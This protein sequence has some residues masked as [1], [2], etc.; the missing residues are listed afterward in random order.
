MHLLYHHLQV[1]VIVNGIPST[2]ASKNCS[3]TFEDSL[4]P[5]VI[6][7]S[8]AMGQSGTNVTI[9]GTGFS[10]KLEDLSVTIGGVACE[11]T[12]ASTEALQCTAGLQSAGCYAV[13]LAIDGVGMAYSDDSICFQY[14]VT[15]DSFSPMMGGVTGGQVITFSGEGFPE[16]TPE[17]KDTTIIMIIITELAKRH[18]ELPWLRY[19]RDTDEFPDE[20]IMNDI[21]LETLRTRMEDINSRSPFSV[22]IG[23]TPC[24]ITE[25]SITEL[26]CIPLP[27]VEGTVAITITVRDQNITLDQE[28]TI[29]TQATPAIA[30]VTPSTGPVTGGTGV[31]ITGRLLSGLAEVFVGKS[32]CV[33]Q[34]SND[35][36]I[37]CTTAQQKPGS[38]PV[39]V[40]ASAGIAVLESEL[41]DWNED[42]NLTDL[43]PVF[44][45]ELR[46][47]EVSSSGGSVF[48]GTELSISGAGFDEDNTQV[49]IGG[50]PAEI[51]S[52][53]SSEIVCFTP[54]SAREHLIDLS[55]RPVV[56]TSSISSLVT[57]RLTWSAD[58]IEV[59]VGDS[60]TWNWYLDLPTTQAL[61]LS[62]YEVEQPNPDDPDTFV[63]RAEGFS[64]VGET[65]QFTVTFTQSGTRYFVTE[66]NFNGE[67]ILGVVH[68]QELQAVRR[69]LEVYVGNYLAEY[70][71]SGSGSP[72]PSGDDA[73]RNRRNVFL[74][75]EEEC[76]DDAIVDASIEG[77]TFDYSP[78]L[79][80]LVYCVQPQTG[81]RLTTYTIT[82]ERFSTNADGNIVTFGDVPCEIATQNDTTITCRM[83]DGADFTPPAFFPLPLSLRNTDQGFGNGYILTPSTA[84]VTLYPLIDEITPREGSVAGGTD[85]IIYGDTF[86]FSMSSLMVS[87][88]GYQCAVTSVLYSEIW[89]RTAASSGEV[90]I[91]DV[92]FHNVGTGNIIPT[93]CDEDFDECTFEYSLSHTPYVQDVSP[94]TISMAGSTTIEITGF[95]FSD[96][97]EENIV[98]LGNSPCIIIT[99]NE[100]EIS[101]EVEALAAAQ[102][103]FS[104]R[105]CNLTEGRCFGN[106]LVEEG[107]QVVSVEAASVSLVPDTGSILGGTLVTISGYGYNTSSSISVIIGSSSCQVTMVTLDTIQC[108]TSASNP[109]SAIVTVLDGRSEIPSQGDPLSFS[110]MTDATPLVS[111]ISPENGQMGDVATLFGAGFGSSPDVIEIFI[112]DEPCEVKE[113]VNTTVVTCELGVNFAGIHEI[114]LAVGG[115][116]IAQIDEGVTFTYNLVLTSFS[117]TT[118]SLAGMNTLLV[119]GLGFD[120][121][122]T[123]ITICDRVCL[124]T[125]DVPSVT[126]IECFVPPASDDLSQV[127]EMLSC[128][129][130]VNSVGMSVT[131][132]EQYVYL[133]D[134]T[135]LVTSVNVTRG[136]TEGGTRLMISGNGFTAEVTV[137]IAGS[138]CTVGTVTES[139]IECTTER[140]GRTVRAKVMVLV[141]GKG[142]A[143]S[144]VYFWYVDVWSS[145][146]TWGGGPLPQEGDFVVVP[147][148]QTL[149]L[150]TK[151]PILG[152]LLVQGGEL[153]F[154]QEKGDNEV[155]LH[156]QGGLITSGGRVEVGTEANPFMSKTQIVLYGHVLSTEIPLYGAK[157]LGLRR[158]ELDLHGRPINVT[159]TRLASTAESGEV[160]IAL[161]DYVDWEIGGRIVLSSTS[162][163]QRENEEMEIES[164]R[165]GD[166]GSILHLTQPLQYQ[167]ISVSQEVA[168]RTLETRG[169]VG[170]LTRNV[171]VRGNVN[172]EW[173]EL[174]PDCPEEF[175]PGQFEVQSCFQGRFG[176]EVVGDQFG[177]QIMIHAAVPNQGHVTARIEHIEVRHAGQ[178]FRLG[179]YPI[180][181]HLNG[182][183]TGSYVR[184]CGV[185]NTFNRAVTIHGVDHLLVEKNVAFN[186]LG[187]AYF[188]EDGI[189][190]YNIIQDNLGVFVRAS[191]SLL[192]VDITPATFW[193]VNANNI[194]RRNA[195]AGGTH[196]G[197]WYRL[198]EHPV[199]PS[200]TTSFCPR[201]QR[202][203]EFSGNTA[204]S[205]GWYGLWV[206]RQYFPSLEGRCGDSDHAP[207][208][209]DNFFSWRNDRGVEFAEVGALQLRNSV[210]L[211]NRLAGVEVTEIESIWSEEMGPLI[212]DTLIVGH[213]AISFEDFC[214]ESGIKTP[215]SYYLTVSGVTFANF[216]RPNCYPIQA[217][218]HCKVRQGGFETRYREISFVNAGDK[219]TKWQWE[220]EHIHRDL[221]GSLTQSEGPR[222]LIPFSKLLNPALCSNHP[223][224]SGGGAGNGTKGSICDGTVQFGRLAVFDPSPS[225]LRFADINITN[226]HGITHLP[227]VFKRLRGTGPGYM[228][229]V[230]LNQTFDITWLEGQALTNISYNSKISGFGVDDYIIMRQ[231]YV[232]SLDETRVAGTRDAVNASV[233][234]DPALADHGDFFVTEQNQTGYIIKGGRDFPLN[235]R[236]T[237]Y[238]T[239]RCFYLDCIP[240]PPPTLPPP[241]PPGRPENVMMWSNVSIW[242]NGE[243]PGEG[244][245]VT[246]ARDMYV[247]VD[248]DTL[249]RLDILMIEGGLEIFDDRNR[250]LVAS[251][252]IINGGR[253]V[254]GYPET[255]FQHYFTIILHGN[256]RTP[257]LLGFEFGSP[258]IGAKA[259]AV[260]GELIL[261]AEPQT[262]PTWSLLSETV[263]PGDSQLTVTEAVDWRP[264]DFV[265]VTSTS[266]DAFETEVFQVVTA[267]QN[268]VN[269]NDSFRYSH[270]GEEATIGSVRYGIRA[271]V[272]H[273]S[274]KIVI[275][276]GGPELAYEQSFGCRVLVSSNTMSDYRG[277]VQLQGVEFRGCGQLGHTESFDPRFALAMVNAGDQSTSYVRECSFHDGFS[278]AVGVFGTDG[279][280]VT[281]TV[282]HSTVGPSII[283]EGTGHVVQRNLASLSQFIGTYRER[284]EPFN[285]LWTANYEIAESTGILFTDNH[286]AGGGKAGIHTDGEECSASSP[287]T[288]QR[289]VAHS[290]L[291]CFHVGYRDGTG[292]GCSRFANMTAYGC[293]H[294]GFF[295]FSRDGVEVL[296][297]LFVNNKAAVYV[298]VIGPASLS[299]VV[300]DK[301]VSIQ[302]TNII[303]ASLNFECPDDD[304]RPAIADHKT[305]HSGIQT[306]SKGH[307]GVVIPTFFSSKGGFPKFPW[308]SAHSY[309]AIGGMSTLSSVSFV[310]F[311]KRCAERKD[312]VLATSFH[313]EDANHPIHVDRIAFASDDRYTVNGLAIQPQFK[314]FVH[315]PD[316]SSINPSDCVDMDCDGLK[317]ILI[318]D[319]DG[320]FCE[321]ESPRSLVSLAELEWDGDRR[322]GIGDFRIPKTMLT[323]SDG[324]RIPVE[325]V[326]PLKGIVRGTSF[327]NESQC[328]YNS[329]W[330]L[331]VCPN[332]DH[333][334]LVMESLDEDT[335]VRR[336]SPIGIGANGFI[337]LLNGPMDNGWCG[338]YTCQERISTF[339]GIV[340]A[341]ANYVVGL[342][343]TNPQ[344]F[345][346][347]LLNS[348][349]QEAV[350][351]RIIYTNPQRLDVYRTRSGQDVYVPPTN[352][353]LLDD[354]NLEYKDFD[355]DL[356]DAQFNPLVSDPHGANYYDRSLKQLHVNIRGSET[357][358]IITTPVIMLSL[359]I[360]T[361]VE[362][363]F[364]EQFL[365]RNLALLLEIP[366]NRIR[367]V[368][369]VM[370]TRRK[371]QA[372]GGGAGMETIELEIGDPPTQVIDVVSMNDTQTNTSDTAD[373]TN[374]TET[375]S[376]SR[377][378]ELTEMVAAAVQTGQIL[379]GSNGTLVAAEIEE[380]VPPPVDP[381][382]GVRATPSTGGPQPEDVGENSTVL[383]FFEQQQLEE[384]VAANDSSPVIRLS[385]PSRLRFTRLLGATGIMEGVALGNQLAPVVT[386][387]DNNGEIAVALGV[388]MSWRLTATLVS[389]P[390]RGFLTNSTVEFVNGHAVFEGLVFSHPGTYV[391]HFIVTIPTSADFSIR[392][393][394]VI[395]APRSL[396]LYITQQPQDGNTTFNLY[397]YPAIRVV[398]RG[399]LLR[400]H[401]WRNSSWF[402]TALVEDVGRRAVL[403]WTREV[404]RGEAYFPKIKLPANGRYRIH[405][406]A[407]TIPTELED[408]LPERITSGS[409]RINTPQFTRFIVNYEVDFDLVLNKEAEFIQVF[410]ERFVSSYPRAE[411]YNTTIRNGSIIVSTFVTARTA[412][413]L[414]DIINQATS[415][416]N[417]TLTLVFNGMT[418]VPS[419][420]VQDPAY[421]VYLEEDRLLLILATT[422]PA[423]VILLCG[424]LLI[425]MVCLCRRRKGAKQEFDIKV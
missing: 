135:P 137:S 204:H 15:V 281:D 324:S 55:A 341:G 265:V 69:G 27:S 216:D 329:D 229:H 258:T 96:T 240:P 123:T 391:L 166:T 112:G 102:Y 195:A 101:C 254:A 399:V 290:S 205:F 234:N 82:G 261:N 371:R 227:Y 142:F 344:K 368:S 278:T 355:P 284:D 320:S 396:S 28:Y 158:G 369:V 219:I 312:A 161:Q 201:K 139:S 114:Q 325:S 342:T 401:T 148:G 358:K 412:R 267:S 398:D 83:D 98:Y 73:Q 286:A 151:T 91:A 277:T 174:L 244:D 383:T 190:Q 185:H 99:S 215:K 160:E 169:E 323:T 1:E 335:E 389:G 232:Q 230:E 380:P 233:L 193:I 311:A 274:R 235:E 140:S 75:P 409:F 350:V 136:G 231:Q 356:G 6:S 406:E 310:N 275:E 171:V 35:T 104:L 182:N 289:N 327:G 128:N 10:D 49:F 357:Y 332:L 364:D 163:S 365:V 360:S 392:S 198:P 418:L 226:P 410:E 272:G 252:I 94:I 180:H 36:H 188:L 63:A 61:E 58:E 367:I 298:T 86:S 246:I 353:E 405:F 236:D 77:A 108:V 192:N 238:S 221:D 296:D 271:E 144:D 68:V 328:V 194:V 213:S 51:V 65:S 202:V 159:W 262:S 403:S 336:L 154:D 189:E 4:T 147:R 268:V 156:T 100:T 42:T 386:M 239:Y 7:L 212:S 46:V 25:S 279:M 388:G 256:N 313:S 206:F 340:A 372:D 143:I 21:E 297:S 95:G 105:V 126:E 127:G 132:T 423:G 121:S 300:G 31:L 249:P 129:V 400:D 45:Y 250:I 361:T 224:S 76:T 110:F 334:M 414:V 187:H 175:R 404:I 422:I 50:V 373:P 359:T 291:H 349:D 20:P 211:D 152:Y 52:V 415:D 352:A 33:L 348:N 270:L 420:V 184:G 385:I 366:E 8:P 214:T 54:S 220:H 130:V 381:T 186:V 315:E 283:V 87:I 309:P 293:Y 280:S 97:L 172:E 308:P 222:L 150:D 138:N 419:M 41:L 47:M 60:I 354:G 394:T 116:G 70:A 255:P 200:F 9:Q 260:F 384:A 245:N 170:Y 351:L 3:F 294:Y 276:S 301:P 218:S 168:G 118:G 119:V 321:E 424:L 326:Y 264:G 18:K 81:T 299:H 37:Q 282:I 117:A 113:L 376:I 382:G 253:L 29:S 411:V 339:Y 343:S 173:N 72:N 345:A 333:L 32:E 34:T 13:E 288:I 71:E 314:V 93:E 92:V 26:L 337:D 145:P 131:N 106:A 251:L 109:G 120:P 67:K 53:T 241:I 124:P 43:F 402:V 64:N 111:A 302:R 14:L 316:I 107:A 24:I 225:S 417:T 370:E 74:M 330:T 181:F 19:F 167:H 155:E 317:H 390:V 38:V 331:Y 208:Y 179:R 407:R 377:L 103:P 183:V 178:A 413:Q 199:G 196:F 66:N 306:P 322:R 197:F 210:M 39:F 425:C 11:L 176:A 16:L 62:V 421:P 304:K 5:T 84:T 57:Y 319:R 23:G 146:F 346:M 78:C 347:H 237:T 305:S 191:S 273:L 395:V 85:I 248:V 374:T 318:R 228:T 88:G 363:F 266:Y 153:I 393:Q 12:Y 134:L 79:T 157:T 362:N 247:I 207:S 416:P 243:L 263:N 217:C 44:T 203:L 89:C 285:A 115:V 307:V 22:S 292:T 209:F 56:V 269:L 379:S 257:E 287:S 177:S 164:I 40:S 397:P 80:P 162:F 408:Y 387:L 17:V 122:D 259:I 133:R 90:T 338:G 242:P 303:S 223:N 125:P 48:G 2:C 375:L 59:T 295:S 165:A 141:S 149:L 30:S 378:N